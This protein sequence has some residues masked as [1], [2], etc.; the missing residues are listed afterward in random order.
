[1]DIEE[2]SPRAKYCTWCDVGFGSGY[3]GGIISPIGHAWF[4]CNFHYHEWWMDNKKKNPVPVIKDEK[5]D[6]DW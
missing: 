6:C 2:R 4:C 5:L 1:M 3:Q